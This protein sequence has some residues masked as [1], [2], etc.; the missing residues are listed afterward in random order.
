I[1]VAALDPANEPFTAY[2]GTVHL[3]SS[4]AAA[5][6][7]S[8]A[9]LTNGVGTFSVTLKQAGATT[10]TATD[11]LEKALAAT[12]SGITVAHAAVDHFGISLS[13]S[14]V[15][16]TDQSMGVIALD[17]YGNQVTNYSGTVSFSSS[18]PIA[19]L[20]PASSLSGGSAIFPVTLR[21][22]GAQT[23]TVTDQSQ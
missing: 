12:S 20:P 17:A 18:D 1:T 14:T 23:V 19:L 4:D 22:A 11:A 7:P 16:G 6:L 15:A 8:D 21:R 2:T 9:T 3:S 10:I 5:A 13:P